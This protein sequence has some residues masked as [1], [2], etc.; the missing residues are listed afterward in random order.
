MK[1]FSNVWIWMVL[2]GGLALADDPKRAPPTPQTSA[3]QQQ[4]MTRDQVLKDIEVTVGFVPAFFRD[5]SP[6]ML[7]S[8][9]QMMKTFEM[10]PTR[11]DSKTKELIG[12]AVASQIP[13]DYCVQFHTQAAKMHNATNEEIQ[14]AVGMAAM[15]R[16]G[17]TVL[18]GM[19]SDKNQFRKDL[20]RMSKGRQQARK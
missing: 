4:P 18:N 7:P 19:Q 2:L 5:I 9:W 14:E 10:A 20:E 16:L 1:R 17:S 11:L 8:F 12:L 6:S 13:C 3:P 15:T